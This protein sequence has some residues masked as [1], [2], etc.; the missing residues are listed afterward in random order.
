[1]IRAQ[2]CAR[3]V[4][5]TCSDHVQGAPSLQQHGRKRRAAHGAPV[6]LEAVRPTICALCGDQ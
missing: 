4:L 6:G 3:K 5:P 1:M 2:I